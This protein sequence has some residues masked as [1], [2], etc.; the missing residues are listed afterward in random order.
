MGSAG[1]CH[2]YVT[3]R[4]VRNL[5]ELRNLSR[6]RPEAA[7]VGVALALA[8]I[9]PYG[10]RRRRLSGI[11]SPGGARLPRCFGGA[12]ALF[13]WY[14]AKET[15]GSLGAA[16]IGFIRRS[17]SPIMARSALWPRSTGL[18][19]VPRN[20]Q[21]LLNKGKRATR[22]PKRRKARRNASFLLAG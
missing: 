12:S 20:V 5:R 7:I 18:L 8:L 14:V 21:C 2:A 13:S 6:G 1:A 19:H 11:G 10:P 16:A 15:Y 4:N 22:V 17:G 9:Y 3:V